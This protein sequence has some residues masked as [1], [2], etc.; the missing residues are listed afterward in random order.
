MFT[1]YPTVEF[2][3]SI[4]RMTDMMATRKTGS[5]GLPL[6]IRSEANA[7]KITYKKKT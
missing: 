7:I 1:S 4:E 2:P 6:Y 5:S 3:I